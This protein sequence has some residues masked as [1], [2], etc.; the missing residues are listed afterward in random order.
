VGALR[1]TKKY[2]W[3]YELRNPIPVDNF[4]VENIDGILTRW[5]MSM[6]DAFLFD[7]RVAFWTPEK[8]EQ[9][10]LLA[11]Q[12]LSANQ[13]SAAIHAPSRNAVI[14]KIKREKWPWHFHSENSPTNQSIKERVVAAKKQRKSP[15]KLSGELG[16]PRTPYKPSEAAN[17]SFAEGGPK[18]LLQLDEAAD[19][20][21]PLGDPLQPDFAYCAAP[22]ESEF[23]P[24]CACHAG[25][26]YERR[27]R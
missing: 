16:L 9:C 7:R 13:I 14:G 22:R 26:A 21:W 10:R 5:R 2:T 15:L 1:N 3:I 12:G 19:C 27:V 23:S 20:R 17:I 11:A 4:F 24:Y 6:S 18:G 8:N 25:I